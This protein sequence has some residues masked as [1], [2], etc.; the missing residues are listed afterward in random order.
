MLDV[1]KYTKL[2]PRKLIKY[3]SVETF[4]Y[5]DPKPVKNAIEMSMRKVINKGIKNSNTVCFHSLMKD[6]INASNNQCAKKINRI[7]YKFRPAPYCAN[8]KIT[9]ELRIKYLMLCKKHKMLPNY[10]A[11]TKVIKH[12]RIHLVLGRHTR[13]QLYVYLTVVRQL[14][15]EPNFVYKVMELVKDGVDFFAAYIVACQL[16]MSNM[17]HHFIPKE[18]NTSYIGQSVTEA[19][20]FF[21]TMWGLYK[22]LHEDKKQE[23]HYNTGSG[24]N[25]N[26]TIKKVGTNILSLPL[27]DAVGIDFERAYASPTFKKGE[28]YFNKAM[29]HE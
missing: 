24:F 1:L 22:V 25:C 2:Q 17:N 6:W 26:T 12:S 28:A 19:Q 18:D 13:N 5:Y 10:V 29:N 14:Q 15:D 11:V 16:G 21:R 8:E 27:I 3:S 23:V 20:I 7:V 4:I 9:N